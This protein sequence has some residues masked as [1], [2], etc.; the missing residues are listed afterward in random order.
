LLADG[1]DQHYKD[2]HNNGHRAEGAESPLPDYFPTLYGCK[3]LALE[4]GSIIFPV[5]MMM[6]VVMC[7]FCHFSL[8][9]YELVLN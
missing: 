9:F 5:R 3:T 1:V 2:S 6:M 4:A 8:A 7:F